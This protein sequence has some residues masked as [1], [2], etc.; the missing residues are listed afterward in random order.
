M[1]HRY[2]FAN[3]QSFRDRTEVSWLLDRKASQGTWARTAPTGE[4]VSLLM[5]VLGAN[6]SGKTALL[7]PV[8]FLDWFVSHSFGLDPQAQLPLQPH[9]AGRDEPSEFE[10]EFDADGKLWRYQLRCTPTRVLHESLHV[11]HER[12]R[13]VFIRDWDEAQQRYEVKQQEF[14]L[15]PAEAR[16]VRPNASL[17]ATAAQYGVALAQRMTNMAVVSNIDQ[18]GR[19]TFDHDQLLRAAQHFAST[20]LQREQ[21]VQ[22]LRSWDLGLKDV[23]LKELESVGSDGTK[24]KY[25]LPFGIHA[26]RTAEHSFALPFTLESSGTQSAMVL[27]SRLL[28]ALEEGGLAVIDELEND[29]HPHMLEPILGLFASPQTNPHG[30]Q[31][32]FTSHAVEV[33]NILH[34]AQV[35]LVE[36]D[37]ANESQAWRLDSMGGVRS[38]DNL[39][40]KY[41]AGAYG[42][43]PQT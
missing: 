20:Q 43:V 18:L 24:N 37:E 6:A 8:V 33:L 26:S 15:L 30:A 28:P 17:I 7:K 41:M 12:M 11:K 9:F 10:V 14:G 27:L 25:W 1:L 21:M 29:L 3:F 34:K 42:A 5:S 35:M 19:K 4:R 31:L 32:L 2:A 40:A 38:D 39:Y 22:L 36:K 16:K 13:Y 23:E